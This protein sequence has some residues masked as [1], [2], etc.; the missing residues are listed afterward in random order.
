MLFNF[1]VA[2]IL[3]YHFTEAVQKCD[4]GFFIVL[5]HLLF[6]WVVLFQKI[7]LRNTFFKLWIP[8]P[9]T[10][11]S[12]QGGCY[13]ATLCYIESEIMCFIPCKEHVAPGVFVMQETGFGLQ[14]AG[15]RVS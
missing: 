7:L 12:R 14:D 10:Y 13:S 11:V 8:S 2:L 1:I 15:E 4:F 6:L 5:Q 3:K 9:P